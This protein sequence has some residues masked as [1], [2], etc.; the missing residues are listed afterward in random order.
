M[1]RLTS[2]RGFALDDCHPLLLLGHWLY[3]KW[4]WW[5]NRICLILYSFCSLSVLGHYIYA[6]PNVLPFRVNLLIAL[7]AL[8][9]MMLMI[10]AVVLQMGPNRPTQ[11]SENAA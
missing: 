5:Q 10:R 2:C 4:A 8:A 11:E 7:E 9:A 3:T 6:S 1:D